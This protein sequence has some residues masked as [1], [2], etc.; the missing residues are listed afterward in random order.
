MN[1]ESTLYHKKLLIIHNGS[2]NQRI[3][4]QHVCEQL[5]IYVDQIADKPNEKAFGKISGRMHFSFYEKILDSYYVQQCNC[6]AERYDYILIIRG[7]YITLNAL[8][9]IRGKYTDAKMILYMWDSVQ[10]NRG[11]EQKW[12]YF[13]AVYTFDRAD[14]IRYAERIGF[15]PLYYCEEY[16]HALDLNQEKCYDIAFIG[17]AHG[18]RMK[19]VK[20]VA[21][22]CI[23]SGMK[24][25]VFSYS[26]HIL[27]YYYNKLF[28][29][30]YREVKKQDLSFHLMSQ[31]EIYEVYSRT[32][33]ILDIEIKSQTG[34]TMR[35][36]D[37]L[38]LKRKLI[39]TNKDIIHYDFYNPQNI[40]VID[41]NHPVIDECF[42]REPYKDI[43]ESIY[44]KYSMRSW[45]IQLLTGKVF[46]CIT[47]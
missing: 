5:G 4:Y 2:I 16:I 46:S 31:K 11:I 10:N 15:I 23:D 44:N 24:M 8:R 32:N 38:G 14:W 29:K 39:T 45:L 21:E 13:D 26:P 47:E 43:P 6:L 12:D 1:Q 19:I 37:I 17:T 30:D 20:Q 42:L 34:L 36:M 41:R 33:C 7:E 25:F 18:D 27:V 9:Y 28:N 3:L 40:S 35:T 22:S